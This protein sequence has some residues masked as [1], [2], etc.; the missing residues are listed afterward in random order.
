[1]KLAFMG[2]PDFAIPALRALVAA[3]HD[4]AAVYA[5][6][7]KPAGRGQRETPCPAGLGGCA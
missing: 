6:P 1:M 5:Q 7:P 3:G 4:I 2:A